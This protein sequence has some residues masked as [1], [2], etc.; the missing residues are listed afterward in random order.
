MEH[1]SDSWR[2]RE[3][4]KLTVCECFKLYLCIIGIGNTVLPFTNEHNNE[5]TDSK[6]GSISLKLHVIILGG[7]HDQLENGQTQDINN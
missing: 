7:C 6:N 1:I 5:R 3:S 2:A 4:V